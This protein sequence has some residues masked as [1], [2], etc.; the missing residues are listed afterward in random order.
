M[1]QDLTRGLYTDVVDIRRRVFVEVAKMIWDYDHHNLPKMKEESA[2]IA[3]KIIPKDT[4]SYRCCVYKERAIVTQRTRLALGLPLWEGALNG[5]VYIG[6][7]NILKPEKIGNKTNPEIVK[8]IPEACEKCPTHAYWVTNNCRKCLAHPCSLVCP[9][10]AVYFDEHAAV[11]DQEKGIKCGRCE[12]ACPYNAITHYHRPCAAA[13]GVDA[14]GSD[15]LGRA[16]IDYN[17][18][19]RCGMCIVACPFGSIGDKSEFVQMIIAIKEKRPV[20]AIIAPSFVGQFGPQVSPGEIVT[21]VKMLGFKDVKEVAYGADVATMQES[22]EW[23][24]KVVEEKQPFLG[25]SCCPAW[26]DM[27]DHFFPDVAENISDSYT[28]MMATGKAIKEKYPDALVTFIGPCTAKKAEILRPELSAYV[29]FVITFEELAAIFVAKDI[30]LADIEES[31]ELKGASGSGRHYA[32]S[33]GVAEALKINVEHDHPGAEVKIAK[34][35]SLRDC[36]T[37]LL[38]ARAGKLDA[39]LLEGMSCPGGCVGGAGIL[40]PIRRTTGEVSKFAKNSIYYPAYENP[41]VAKKE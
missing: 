8:V 24:H 11:I 2:K 31:D 33:G 28:P 5:P 20:Y 10:D 15:E 13:C 25:T 16:K 29:D 7:E 38:Q 22:K 17:R 1:M 18:C 34:A 23:Y 26:V 12:Q 21:A 30:D 19:V 37:M 27:A 9:V 14:I 6:I 4:P 41:E 36:R 32:V 39:N 40:A 35:D 3:F